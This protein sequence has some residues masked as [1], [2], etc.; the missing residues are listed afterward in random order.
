[1]A[2]WLKVYLDILISM[3]AFCVTLESLATCFA[4]FIVV[5]LIPL[6]LVPLLSY[7]LDFFAPRAKLKIQTK[8]KWYKYFL[9]IS[10]NSR[11]L[12]LRSAIVLTCQQRRTRL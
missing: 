8:T 2:L 1:M 3:A 12:F 6:F 11:N 5:V 9:R 10:K 4:I 7:L